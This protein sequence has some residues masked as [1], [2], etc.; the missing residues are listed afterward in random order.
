MLT[1][2]RRQIKSLAEC[3]GQEHAEHVQML[4]LS[5]TADVVHSI[6]KKVD[7]EQCSVFTRKV[8]IPVGSKNNEGGG[9]KVRAST[10]QANAEPNKAE[11]NCGHGIVLLAFGWWIARM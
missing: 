4:H 3:K 6:N 2:C 7:V 11:R 8:A 9:V 1:V 5:S 10:A